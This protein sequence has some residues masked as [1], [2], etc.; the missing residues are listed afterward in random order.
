MAEVGPSGIKEINVVG[1][2]IAGVPAC[3]CLLIAMYLRRG[4]RGIAAAAI[5][6]EGLWIIFTVLTG[7]LG[8]WPSGALG[9]YGL[10]DLV[11]GIASVTAFIGLLRPPARRFSSS[12]QDRASQHPS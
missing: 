5:V 9:G 4:R 8:M 7:L 3:G 2:F 12:A 1:A 11:I 10:P 6:L